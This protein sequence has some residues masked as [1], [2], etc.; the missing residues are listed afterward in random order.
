MPFS[1]FLPSPARELDRLEAARAVVLWLIM[2]TGAICADMR[3]EA[4]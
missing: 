1:H 2:S 3:W 4:M